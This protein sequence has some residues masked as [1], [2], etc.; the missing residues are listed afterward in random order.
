MILN[1]HAATM[2]LS[3]AVSETNDDFSRKSQNFPTPVYLSP[4]MK[5][6]PL[7]LGTDAK[8]QKN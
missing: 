2:S 6:F 8:G 3:R 7:E 1:L 5:R 4:P